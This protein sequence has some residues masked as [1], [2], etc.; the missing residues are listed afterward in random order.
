[1][2]LSTVFQYS[3]SLEE[4]SEV[5][6]NISSFEVNGRRIV[7]TDLLGEEYILEGA[8]TNVDFVKSRIMVQS[9][10]KAV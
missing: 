5:C 6:S 9:E 10:K 3:D 2:C 8:I 7:F 1:M 4:A